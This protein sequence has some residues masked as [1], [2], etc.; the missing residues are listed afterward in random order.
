MIIPEDG[1]V[2]TKKFPQGIFATYN[3]KPDIEFVHAN[4]T[5]SRIVGEASD[6][7]STKEADGL[8]ISNPS[9]T[10]PL[11]IK[12]ADCIPLLCIGKQGVAMLHAGWKG[13]QLNIH[14]H[15]FVKNLE[16]FSFFLGPYAS[17]E[18]YEVQ[19]DFQ[20][21]FPTSQ[22]FKT[23]GEKI[24]FNLGQELTHRLKQAYP[25]SKI[26]ESSMCTITSNELHSFRENQTKMRNWN[27]FFPLLMT[28]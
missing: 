14:D 16:P 20:D 4:Q 23:K 9:F 1:L 15:E 12:T 22:A 26:Q 21:H 10:T 28:K 11:C 3:K 27:L 17:V 6:W 25:E 13:I 2:F 18:K 5:H 8:V 7:D 19:K 24:F